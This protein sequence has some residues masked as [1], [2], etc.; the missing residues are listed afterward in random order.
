MS[1]ENDGI[2]AE[3]VETGRCG[4]TD[5][6]HDAL[7]DRRTPEKAW[8]EQVVMERLEKVRW[9][10]TCIYPA[11]ETLAQLQRAAEWVRMMGHEAADVCEDGFRY[12]SVYG[13]GRFNRWTWI[14]PGQWLIHMEGENQAREFDS[15]YDE[16]PAV[17]D[18]PEDDSFYGYRPWPSD[19]WHVVEAP[20]PGMVFRPGNPDGSAS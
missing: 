15:P 9:H 2:C 8:P 3:F 17:S 6:E 12:R 20:T 10:R 19:E 4:H 14:E 18:D 7:A 13:G 1:P 5:A 11:G 16:A